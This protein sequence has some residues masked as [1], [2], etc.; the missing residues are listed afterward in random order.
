ML[1]P[2]VSRSSPAAELVESR[3]APE[4]V[5]VDHSEDLHLPSRWHGSLPDEDL[6]HFQREESVLS[7]LK[8]WLRIAPL[9]MVLIL[10]ESSEL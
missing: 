2:E 4:H 9:K 6:I 7:C 5:L 3:A 8:I 1:E 10:A